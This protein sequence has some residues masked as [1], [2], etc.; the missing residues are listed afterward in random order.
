MNDSSWKIDYQCP[1]CSAPVILDE[2]DR[3]LS[4]PY[5]RTKLYLIKEDG[6]RYLIPHD[7]TAGREIYYL[8]YWRVKGSRFCFQESQVRFRFVDLTQKAV[9]I[10]MIPLSLGVRPQAMKL[11]FLTPESQGIFL[12][13]QGKAMEV[14][15]PPNEPG[16]EVGGDFIGEITSLIYTPVYLEGKTLFDAVTNRRLN[17][18]GDPE[19]LRTLPRTDPVKSAKILFIPTL[20]P[21]CG[22][23]LEGEK[24]ALTLGCHNCHTLWQCRKDRLE[25]IA[26]TIVA[27]PSKPDLYLPFW[28]MK[29]AAG[30]FCLESV[31]DLIR[32]ANLPKVSTPELESMPLHLWSPAFKINPA[33]YMR[34]TR[35]MTV[36]QLPVEKEPNPESFPAQALHP[37]TLPLS[38]A[39]EG[40]RMNI[41]QL[42]SDKRRLLKTLAGTSITLLE[43]ELVYQPFR[44]QNSELIHTTLGLTV[45]RNALSLAVHLS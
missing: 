32:L 24:D 40:V 14:A 1:Q 5:C 43:A 39:V 34:W 4:C 10:P 6:F 44:R 42:L 3:L 28:K 17:D 12:A 38:E 23:N 19:L 27:S 7:E 33:L 2:T 22:W 36:V 37:V 11:R 31:G 8:P 29:I 13:P 45:D 18:L 30:G 26:F 41:A 21:R 15:F 16:N 25:T 20:C 9:P 35:Q